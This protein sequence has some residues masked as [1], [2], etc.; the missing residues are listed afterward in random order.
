MKFIATNDKLECSYQHL[1]I[2]D[3]L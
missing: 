3:A 1:I 2:M